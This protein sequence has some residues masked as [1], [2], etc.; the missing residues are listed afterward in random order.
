[1]REWLTPCGGFTIITTYGGGKDPMGR[2]KSNNWGEFIRY[3]R[4]PW[5]NKELQKR[6]MEETMKYE[7]E[8][9]LFMAS[10]DGYVIR[11]MHYPDSAFT[12]EEVPVIYKTSEENVLIAAYPQSLIKRL[13]EITTEESNKNKLEE[14]WEKVLQTL[15][16]VAELKIK[17]GE[18]HEP[19]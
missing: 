14:D 3:I 9:F 10:G 8:N 2:D 19:Y 15:S 18:I 13:L 17:N 16:T 4:K 1:M 11:G 7:M 12:S 6:L 5:E